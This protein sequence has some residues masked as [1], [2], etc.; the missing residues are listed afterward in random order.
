LTAITARGKLRAY[1]GSVLRSSRGVH[2]T[3][4]PNLTLATVPLGQPSPTETFLPL[5]V[6]HHASGHTP[7]LTRRP[8]ALALI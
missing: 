1:F 7:K 4:N 5:L 6:N 2:A 8:A 3:G